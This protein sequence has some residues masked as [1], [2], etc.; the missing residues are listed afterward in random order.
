M[1]F[2]DP[3]KQRRSKLI[4]SIGYILMALAIGIGTLVLLYQA[5]GFGVD[6]NGNVIQN[7]LLF[8]SSQP[9]GAQIYLNGKLNG[10][11]TNSRLLVPSGT[12]NVRI[13]ASGYRDWQ[14]EVS[15]NGGDVQHFDYPFLFPKTLVTK[16]VAS[17]AAVPAI[18]TQSLD[19]RWLLVERTDDLA[20]FD[21]Y[22]LQ[23]PKTAAV[24]VTIPVANYTPG[25]G[26]QSWAVQEWSSDNKHVLLLHTFM[27]AS[28]PA[29]EYIVLD[30]QTPDSSVN[31]T[32]ATGLPATAALSLFNKKFDQYYVFDQ[33]AGALSTVTLSD[34]SS[35]LKLTHVLT[36]K[37]YGGDTVLY[38]TDQSPN[39]KQLPGEVSVVLA[40]GQKVYILRTMPAT[41][42]QYLLDLA[43]YSGDWYV[44]VAASNDKAAYLY[45]NPQ[46]RVD[47]SPNSLPK[48]TR[49]LRVNQPTY[50]SFS[51]N[52]RFVMAENGQGFGVYDAET[53]KGYN[54][55][56]RL[57]LD[58]PQAH[59]AWMD[60]HRLSFVSGGKIAVFDYDSLNLQ[61]LQAANPAYKSFFTPDYKFVYSL[62]SP[63]DVTS[64]DALQLTSTAL[65][66]V[67]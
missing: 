24:P 31:V 66:V 43:T 8:F 30:R 40:Q 15:V 54:Y 7:G 3:K 12:Y 42:P 28:Q 14:R 33:A 23:N 65:T 52:G 48:V 63:V 16:P 1:D 2:L 46:S 64:K 5:Y 27:Q 53:I 36:Y 39:G 19:R 26:A 13:A 67:K 18:A 61:V 20:T 22:D 35:K 21:E 45:K 9:S 10:A 55:T 11:Q 59:A 6:K 51:S 37:Q 44:V 29:H 62:A 56:V 58:Q 57:P 4:L 50:I 47:A 17:F 60:G 25:S 49:L 34:P 32:K 38:V 41:S